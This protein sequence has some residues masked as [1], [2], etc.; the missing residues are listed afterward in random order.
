MRAIGQ[1]L[2]FGLAHLSVWS[3]ARTV[4][5]SRRLSRQ[6]WFY[7]QPLA[8]NAV[9]ASAF[10]IVDSH[11]RPVAVVGSRS[12]SGG[13]RLDA[14]AQPSPSTRPFPTHCGRWLPQSH[15]L[16]TSKRSFGNRG[17][18]P[19][20]AEENKPRRSGVSGIGNSGVYARVCLLRRAMTNAPKPIPNRARE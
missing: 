10:L 11:F 18:S 8:R 7:Y 20:P 12:L 17:L 19:F 5:G 14:A 6:V 4:I 16:L 9:R 15:R 1:E 2:P 13:S 3:S